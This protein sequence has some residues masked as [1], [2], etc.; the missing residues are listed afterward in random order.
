[1][2]IYD[3]K[4]WSSLFN[5][6]GKVFRQSYSIKTLSFFMACIMVYATIITVVEQQFFVGTL[7]VESLFFSLAGIVLSLFLV[8]RL[9]SAYDRWW[10]GR[11]AWGKLINDS[12]SFA[13]QLDCLIPMENKRRR[14]FFVKNIANFCLALTWHLRNNVN[15]DDFI[16]V[17]RATTEDLEGAKHVPNRIVSYMFNEVEKMCEEHENISQLDKQQVKYLLQGFIDVLGICERIKK[18]PIPF[19]HSIFIKVFVIIYILILPFGLVNDFDYLTIPAVM[20]MGF[21]MMGVEIISEEI[22]DPFGLEANCLP[23]GLMSDTIRENVYEILKVKSPF[24]A[25][26]N[27][28]EADVVR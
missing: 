17:N 16:Y 25:E 27:M 13:L 2:I 3:S 22:E 24:V 5:T 4:K 19:S 23:T 14:K 21:A 8:F 10:E 20:V 1:M 26:T 6:T 18:T 15:R 7:H 28:K 11:K 9:N 12:R